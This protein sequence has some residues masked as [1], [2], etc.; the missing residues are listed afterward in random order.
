MP[1]LPGL[2]TDDESH[3]DLFEEMAIA[4]RE[5]LRS[6]LL[7]IGIGFALAFIVGHLLT[8]PLHGFV[9][10]NTD[11]WRYSSFHQVEPMGNDFS[12][13]L[14]IA[15][16]FSLLLLFY[17]VVAFV[18]PGLTRKEQRYAYGSLAFVAI[19][20]IS[21]AALAFL[22]MIPRWL[23]FHSSLVSCIG[24]YLPSDLEIAS[25]Y[26]QGSL[27]MGIAFEWLIIMVLLARLGIIN[28]SRLTVPRR[29]LVIGVMVAAA[30]ITPTVDPASMLLLAGAFWLLYEVG[31]VCARIA[32][33]GRYR[34]RKQY[35]DIPALAG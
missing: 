34:Q 25:Q 19:A 29:S 27:A 2:S 32:A 9:R 1:S 5:E 7:K 35:D 23:E 11:L 17:E 28:P 21:G 8:R 15:I 6:R 3:F 10:D 4:E 33:R 20:F 31:V 13:G 30:I 18:S 24:C 14:G 12:A 26:L 16:A 22:V